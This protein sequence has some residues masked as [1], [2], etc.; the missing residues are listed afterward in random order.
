MKD[1]KIDVYGKRQTAKKVFDFTTRLL[2]LLNS[3][4]IY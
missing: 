3:F 1:L 2:K 4:E